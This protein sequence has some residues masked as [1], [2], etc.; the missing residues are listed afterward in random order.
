MLFSTTE[1]L[2]STSEMLFS[3]SEGPRQCLN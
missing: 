1:M 3:T 2:F